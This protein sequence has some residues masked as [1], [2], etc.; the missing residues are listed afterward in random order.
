MLAAPLNFDPLSCCYVLSKP[1]ARLAA[2]DAVDIFV[3]KQSGVQATKVARN[4]GVSEKAVRDIWTARTWARETWHLDQS[5]ELELK[6]AGRPRG[7]RDSRPRQT[8]RLVSQR[9]LSTVTDQQD[10]Q[11]CI[12]PH[13]LAAL[14]DTLTLHVPCAARAG[15]IASLCAPVCT[16]MQSVDEQLSEWDWEI[17]CRPPFSDPF[18]HDWKKSNRCFHSSTP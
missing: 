6:K 1:R 18:E 10:H 17:W 4:Y 7:S 16:R 8:K 3:L 12:D 14:P 5:R 11:L 13:T 15:N 2:N 9:C